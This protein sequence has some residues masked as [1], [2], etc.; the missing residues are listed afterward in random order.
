[1]NESVKKVFFKRKITYLVIFATLI[2]VYVI[3][4][5]ATEFHLSEGLASFPKAM[6]W[7]GHNLMPDEKAMERFPKI[8]DKLIET[9]LLSVA[10]TVIAAIFAF[11]FSL[12]G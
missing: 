11:C 4:A 7:I 2:A 6:A 3:S 12:F 5:S 1:M 9:A 8:L 10:V